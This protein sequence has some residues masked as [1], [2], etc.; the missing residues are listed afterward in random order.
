MRSEGLGGFDSASE[1]AGER[2][3]ER[4]SGEKRPET[5]NSALFHRRQRA[6]QVPSRTPESAFGGPCGRAVIR[7]PEGGPCLFFV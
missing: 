1:P 5:R 6:E 3:K 4:P 2:P 7:G